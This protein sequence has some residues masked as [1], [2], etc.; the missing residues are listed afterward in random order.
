MHLILSREVYASPFYM[1]HYKAEVDNGAYVILDNSAHE[2]G[3]GD[4]GDVLL[5]QALLIG[6]QEIVLPDVLFDARETY[7]LSRQALRVLAECARQWTHDTLS[8]MIVPQAAAVSEW[9][10]LL[11]ELV[12]LYA[13]L[14]SRHPRAL[15]QPVLGI[16]KDYFSAWDGGIRRL[17]DAGLSL[18]LDIHLLGWWW[19]GWE[20]LGQIAREYGTSIRSIDSAKP[21]VYALR[22]IK[23]IPG[24]PLPYV[25]RPRDFFSRKLTPEQIPI[26]THN[27]EVFN[28]LARGGQ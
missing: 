25:K 17:I 18:N 4:P 14:M 19:K 10:E 12:E 21:L 11:V 13:E 9:M 15:P 27:V 28:R 3:R 6:A 26:A 5:Q 20:E 8:V 24:E 22:G 23:L 7:R 1:L 16:S 2:T